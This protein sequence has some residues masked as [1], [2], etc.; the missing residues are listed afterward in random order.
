ML[1]YQ[2]RVVEAEQSFLVAAL[3]GCAY[4]V[5]LMEDCCKA[6]VHAAAPKL[7][8]VQTVK[9][10]TV[11]GHMSSQTK[12]VL[13]RLVSLFGITMLLQNLGDLMEDDYASR[14]QVSLI[15]QQQYGL[16]RELRPDAVALVDGFGFEDYLLNSALGRSVL[17]VSQS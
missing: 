6:A 2:K 4:N 7:W 1:I 5:G 15:R 8:T 3:L 16:L 9:Y 14:Q 11:Q 10:V 13:Q 12:A 17:S